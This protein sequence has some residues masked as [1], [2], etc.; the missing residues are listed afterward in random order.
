EFFPIL[1]AVND[2]RGEEQFV[3]QC[4]HQPAAVA[5][6]EKTDGCPAGAAATDAVK[7]FLQ[8]DHGA[9]STKPDSIPGPRRFSA[10]GLTRQRFGMP[11]LHR[12]L[13]RA[14]HLRI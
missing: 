14:G 1:Y 11:S 3:R 8:F 10:T 5:A 4:H 13:D 7:K 9:H 12:V 2:S 6:L